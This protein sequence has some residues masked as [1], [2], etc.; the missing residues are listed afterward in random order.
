MFSKL[1][2]RDEASR[3]G[4]PGGIVNAPPLAFWRRGGSTS[5]AAAIQP[6]KPL[7]LC[8]IRSAKWTS[9]ALWT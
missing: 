2:S 5:L 3:L 1:T 7:D 6:G 9:T 8:P 4:G